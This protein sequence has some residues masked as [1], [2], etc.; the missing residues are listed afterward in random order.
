MSVRG[1]GEGARRA[2]GHEG[3]QAEPVGL[4]STPGAQATSPFAKRGAIYTMTAREGLDAAEVVKAAFRNRTIGAI[5]PR[6]LEVVEPDGP[7]TAGGKRARQTIRLV[8]AQGEGAPVMCGFLDV[9]KKL[10]ELRSYTV[11]AQQYAERFTKQFDVTPSEYATLCRDLESTLAVFN[12]EFVREVETKPA[13]EG[14]RAQLSSRARP[15][16]RV[17]NVVLA[18]LLAAVVAGLLALVALR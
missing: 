5:T 6:R 11:V 9:A 17:L 4:A 3:Q 7:S 16:A 1:E 2:A 15:H 18:L 14:V 13:A 10:V 8:P 12:Y